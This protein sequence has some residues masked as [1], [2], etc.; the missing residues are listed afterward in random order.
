MSSTQP[1]LSRLHFRGDIVR[2]D[3]KS[4]WE[5]LVPIRFDQGT[6]PHGSVFFNIPENL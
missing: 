5:Q 1:V 4:N 3:E 6:V 2:T